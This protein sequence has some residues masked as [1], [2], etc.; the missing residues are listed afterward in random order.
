[1]GIEFG[2]FIKVETGEPRRILS[3]RIHTAEV[4]RAGSIYSFKASRHISV[5][6][7]SLVL[8]ER[9]HIPLPSKIDVE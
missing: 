5:S 2:K 7:R 6:E 3:N 4:F 8:L 1:M 9:F